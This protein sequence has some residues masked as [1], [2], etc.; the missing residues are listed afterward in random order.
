[1][2]ADPCS[3]AGFQANQNDLLC[4]A[5]IGTQRL[6]YPLI[7]TSSVKGSLKDISKGSIREL[8]DIPPIIVG[9]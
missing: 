4:P 6:Q 3:D 7:K 1:M 5:R 8:R 9:L 2:L